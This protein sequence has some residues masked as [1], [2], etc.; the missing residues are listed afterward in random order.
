MY[1]ASCRQLAL[2]MCRGDAEDLWLLHACIYLDVPLSLTGP[3]SCRRCRRRCCRRRCCRRR[4]CRRRCCRRRCCRCHPPPLLLPLPPPLLLLLLPPLL[5]RMCLLVKK[6]GNVS[7][8]ASIMPAYYSCLSQPDAGHRGRHQLQHLPV[9]P[10]G[11]GKQ[12]EL[13]VLCISSCRRQRRAV[14]CGAAVAGEGTVH[15]TKAMPGLCAAKWE[16]SE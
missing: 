6:Q 11:T 10:G 3:L 12:L 13:L 15:T 14:R 4:C 7:S 9:Q 1:G 8:V 16:L 5:L 2:L